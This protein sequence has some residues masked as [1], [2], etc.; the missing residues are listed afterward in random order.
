VLL[1]AANPLF[2]ASKGIDFF[3]SEPPLLH[4]SLIP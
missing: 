3:H 2:G 4:R 1:C